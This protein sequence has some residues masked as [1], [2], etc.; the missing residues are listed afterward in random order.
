MATE[1]RLATMYSNRLKPLP[2]RF[3]SLEELK[4]EV[5]KM[6]AAQRRGLYYYQGYSGRQVGEPARVSTLSV[7]STT[8]AQQARMRYRWRRR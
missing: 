5:W 2:K 1:W 7:S 6:T 8:P 3:R 4:E